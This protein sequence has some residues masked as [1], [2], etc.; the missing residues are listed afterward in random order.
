[1]PTRTL[2]QELCDVCYA[3]D[4]GSETAA[5]DRLRFSW[6]GQD[7][8][9]LACEAHIGSVRDELQHLSEIATPAGGRR[10]SVVPSLP[11]SGRQAA[12][13]RERGGTPRTERT[14]FS[15]LSDEEKERFRKWAKMP[16]A[17]RIVDSRVEEWAAAGRP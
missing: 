14:L 11:R 10:R 8:V 2:I 4:H 12:E 6:Q 3:D 9:L 13:R 17:R 16:N 15:Q 7:Y 1:M 5:S